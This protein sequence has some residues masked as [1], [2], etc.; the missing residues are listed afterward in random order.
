[1]DGEGLEASALLDPA[2]GCSNPTA[3]ARNDP[4]SKP[5]AGKAK[6]FFWYQGREARASAAKISALVC[7]LVFEDF[8]SLFPDSTEFIAFFFLPVSHM[9]NTP[10]IPRSNP[11]APPTKSQLT[12]PERGETATA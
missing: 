6:R 1:V 9:N 11:A 8:E 12:G 2:C 5:I 4:A 7:F 10:I 3:I